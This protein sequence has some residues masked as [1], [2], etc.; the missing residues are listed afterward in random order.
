MSKCSVVIAF[1][2]V[3]N[4]T[5]TICLNEVWDDLDKLSSFW[6][7]LPKSKRPSSKSYHTLKASLDDK[8][9]QVKLHFL[10]I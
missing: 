6:H 5:V 8:L 1:S 2:W 9:I 7:S 10:S 3:E 4:K